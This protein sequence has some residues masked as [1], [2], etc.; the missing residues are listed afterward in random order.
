[1]S[2]MEN[3]AGQGG[4]PK[5][6]QLGGSIS[7]DNTVSLARPQAIQLTRP[8]AISLTTAAIVAPFLYREGQR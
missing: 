1:M 8:C 3:P 2:R 6:D 5:S 7:S 4:A